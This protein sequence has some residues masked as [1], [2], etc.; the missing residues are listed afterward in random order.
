MGFVCSKTSY[1]LTVRADM[2]AALADQHARDLS[3]AARA[4]FAR[5]PVDIK[6]V[7]KITSAIDPVDAGTITLD[8]LFSHRPH[9]LQQ[10]RAPGLCQRI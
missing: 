6:I 9:L 4:G 7:L 8:T 10:Q 2:R 3:S 1:L 5:A